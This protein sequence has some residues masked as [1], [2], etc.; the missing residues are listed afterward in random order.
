MASHVIIPTCPELPTVPLS[1]WGLFSAKDC[2][3]VFCYSSLHSLLQAYFFFYC[4]L[5]SAR[6]LLSKSQQP[7]SYLIEGVRVRDEQIKTG[8]ETIATLERDVRYVCYYTNAGLHLGGGGGGGGGFCPPPPP[9]NF[10]P[11]KL[12]TD[13]YM[14]A[15]LPKCLPTCLYPPLG[16]FLNEPLKWEGST[17][18]IQFKYWPEQ[19]EGLFRS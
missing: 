7:Y 15:P 18:A 1:Q 16:I 12:N 13:Y 14:H 6:E 4:Q 2:N 5:S 10:N 8:R 3:S 9:W 11:S 19:R 17:V